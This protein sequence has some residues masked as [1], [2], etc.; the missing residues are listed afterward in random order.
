MSEQAFE[1]DEDLVDKVFWTDYDKGIQYRLCISEFYG[2]RYLGIRKWVQTYHPEEDCEWIPTR[3]GMTMPYELATTA[4][5][6]NALVD[7]L[8]EAEVLDAVIKEK[9]NT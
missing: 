1:T 2:K 8:S 3:E 5:L 9:N 6:W 4:A 7:M